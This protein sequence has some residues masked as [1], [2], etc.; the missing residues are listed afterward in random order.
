MNSHGIEISIAGGLEEIVRARNLLPHFFFFSFFLL[1]LSCFIV[2]RYNKLH[3]ALT[4]ERT[5]PINQTK[6]KRNH[7]RESTTNLK[8]SL[9]KPIANALAREKQKFKEV[10]HA[11][12]IPCF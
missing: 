7:I 12:K 10:Q 3:A 2:F 5:K 1:F 9:L 6:P 11:N 4:M 8:T